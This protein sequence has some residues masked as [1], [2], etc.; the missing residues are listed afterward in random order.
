[1]IEL[2]HWEPVGHSARVLICLHE[3]GVEFKS[4]YVDLL[5]FEHF[6]DAFLAMNPM[7]QVPVL[8]VDDVVMT[9]SSL[10]NEYLAES[11]PEAGL[12]QLDALG[13]YQTQAWSKYAD[14]NLGSSLATLGCRKCLVPRL[15]D[16][17]EKELEKSIEA[18][19]VPERRAGWEVAAN[20]A[21]TDEMIGNSERK[22]SLVIGRMEKVL[23]D[24]QWLAGEQ[25]SIAD[26]DTFAMMRSFPDLAPQIANRNDAPATFDWLERIAARPAVEEALSKYARL[27]PGTAFAPGPEHSRWG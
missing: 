14:Y 21:Y 26:I 8:R 4:Y 5:Q 27:D 9:E 23:A 25:Y 11:Y 10:I 20:D 2:F 1:M 22:L 15:R 19:P 13:W 3:V 7:G 24:A 18:I 17:D 12:A 6:S 16:M